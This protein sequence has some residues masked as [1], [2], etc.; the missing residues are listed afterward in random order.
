MTGSPGLRVLATRRSVLA[1]APSLVLGAL[2]LLGAG[3]P[4][5]ARAQSTGEGYLFQPPVGSIT[6]RGGYAHASASGDLFDF[7]TDQLTL[8][9]GDF[10]SPAGQVDLA[11]RVAPRVDL[12][13]GVG[14]SRSSSPSEYRHLIDQNDQPIEQTTSF[15]RVPITAD[16][17]LYLTPRGRTI[18]HF[19]WVPARF[20]PYVGVGGGMVGYEF[21]QSGDF[22]DAN[23]NNVFNSD[24]KSSGWVPEAQGVVGLDYTLTPRFALTGE[25]KYL[26]ARGRPN[27]GFN[28]FDR[29]D[30]SG[31]TT[32]IGLKLRF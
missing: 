7:V 1:V 8:N 31:F 13:L 21:R 27:E 26:W 15:L 12:D 10:S 9:S 5:S 28:G 24:L 23:T 19:A 11:V 18:G 4:R 17:R 16:V 20:A 32:T 22:V 25:G 29:I 14:V 6:V 3:I 2:L 30:L